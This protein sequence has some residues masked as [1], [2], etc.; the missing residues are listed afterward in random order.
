[1]EWKFDYVWYSFI[2]AVVLSFVLLG[3]GVRFPINLVGY[4]LW[5][6]TFYKNHTTRNK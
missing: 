4:I 1:M 6:I 5:I 2:F 3:L